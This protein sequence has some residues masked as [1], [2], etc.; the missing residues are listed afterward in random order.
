MGRPAD[1]VRGP[2]GHTARAMVKKDPLMAEIATLLAEKEGEGN[3][4]QLERALTDGYARAL[5][6]EAQ[7]WRLEQRIGELTTTIAS[8][9]AESQREL[10]EL[11]QLLKRQEG[12]IGALR[13]DL[14]RLRQR[15]SSA[16]RA[17]A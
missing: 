10:A 16:V 1:A 9:G 7:R 2:H 3:P 4:A 11:I 6:L 12:D 15:H 17:Q 13:A 5:S 8:G 14:G